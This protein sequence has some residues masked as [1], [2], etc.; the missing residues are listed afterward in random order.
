MRMKVVHAHN[1][2]MVQDALGLDSDWVMR[3]RPLLE[4]YGPQILHM[5]SIRNPVADA[6][7][8]QSISLTTLQVYIYCKTLV[9]LTVIIMDV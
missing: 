8:R 9:K 5:I 4:K 7:I 3:W 2:S 1:K 6:I